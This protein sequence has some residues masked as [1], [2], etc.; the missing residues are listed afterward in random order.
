MSNDAEDT[1]E[2][3]ETVPAAPRSKRPEISSH[4]KEHIV[5]TKVRAFAAKAG[6]HPTNGGSDLKP[7]STRE[8]AVNCKWTDQSADR[9]GQIT[10]EGNGGTDIS[11]GRSE[12]GTHESDR[13]SD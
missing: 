1:I 4:L 10:P 9:P 12:E 7:H 13:S 5:A 11:C 6:E 3:I 8:G 2:V